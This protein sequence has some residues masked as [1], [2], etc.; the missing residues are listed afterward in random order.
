M[1]DM[2][3]VDHQEYKIKCKNFTNRFKNAFLI[4][5]V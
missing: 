2:M 5:L 4:A 3:I 1:Y